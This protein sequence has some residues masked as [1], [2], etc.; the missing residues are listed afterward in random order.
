MSLHYK[1]VVYTKPKICTT[2]KVSFKYFYQFILQKWMPEDFT[3]MFS[4]DYSRIFSGRQ[5]SL[6][7][8]IIRK[9]LRPEGSAMI[10]FTKALECSSL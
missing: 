8:T 4:M 1:Y 10:F 9:E 2:F 7:G 3:N 6:K 5:L